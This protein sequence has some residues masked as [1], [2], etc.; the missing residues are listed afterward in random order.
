MIIA[1]HSSMSSADGRYVSRFCSRLYDAAQLLDV[2]AV[3]SFQEV[4][5]LRR[6]GQGF[7]I[8]QDPQN[9]HGLLLQA[10]SRP[11]GE[12][13]ANLARCQSHSLRSVHT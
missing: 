1:G 13:P 10:A 3:E 11:L 4:A 8:Q 9:F 7:R 2:A 12:Q 6:I 5:L